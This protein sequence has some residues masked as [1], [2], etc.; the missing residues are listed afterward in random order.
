MLSRQ[1][2]S[3]FERLTQRSRQ[4]GVVLI[5]VLVV[6]IAMT[7]A[8][9]AMMRSVGTTTLVAGNM[10]LRQATIHAADIG[11]ETAITF[12]Q[13]N[14]AG[15]TLYNDIEQNAYYSSQQG[16]DPNTN[17]TWDHYWTTVLDPAPVTRP[18]A[19]PVISGKVMTLPTDQ[20]T[21]TTV[22][23]II[24]RLCNAA[25]SSPTAV[26]TYC[27]QSPA[28]TVS[29]GNSKSAGSIALKYNNQVYYRITTRVEGPRN[30]VSYV[31]TVIAL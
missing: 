23:Y 26:G 9:I 30:S 25:N 8:G 31:Q 29:N 7:L 3:L 13:T 18:V 11:I 28:S 4:K 1:S 19:A 5:I 24:H 20:K 22:S 6:L 14:S 2:S 10:A 15:V 17:E 21:G 16:P 12:L 27:A